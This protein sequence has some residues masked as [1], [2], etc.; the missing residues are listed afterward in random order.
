VIWIRFG[1]LPF[2]M[3]RRLITILL[4]AGSVLCISGPSF[5]Q[6]QIIDCGNPINGLR[7]GLGS[8]NSYLMLALQNVSEHDLTLNLGVTMA[9]GTGHCALH[10]N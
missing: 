7:T 5:G 10:L 6:Q 4:T 2:M 8:S 1:L 3:S 9:N